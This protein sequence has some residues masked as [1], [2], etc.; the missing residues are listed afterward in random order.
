MPRA[1]G[2]D[3][4]VREPAQ[5]VVGAS[6]FSLSGASSLLVG[7]LHKPLFPPSAGGFLKLAG[8][9]K[10]LIVATN[11]NGTDDPTDTGILARLEFLRQTLMQPVEPFLGQPGDQAATVPAVT[12]PLANPSSIHMALPRTNY[13]FGVDLT[14]ADVRSSLRR[15][16]LM[17]DRYLVD[18]NL[19]DTATPAAIRFLG[20]ELGILSRGILGSLGDHP[21][22]RLRDFYKIICLILKGTFLDVSVPDPYL[23]LGGIIADQSPGTNQAMLLRITESLGW[24]LLF[25]AGRALFTTNAEAL[26][27]TSSKEP[28]DVKF[29]GLLSEAVVL[30]NPRGFNRDASARVATNSAGATVDHVI[31]TALAV[32]QPVDPGLPAAAVSLYAGLNGIARNN[33]ISEL[34]GQPLLQTIRDL[35]H[36]WRFATA[37]SLL[38]EDRSREEA[39]FVLA[40]LLNLY[41]SDPAVL[42]LLSYVDTSVATTAFVEAFGGIDGEDEMFNSA[43]AV[44]A[45]RMNRTKLMMKI[46]HNMGRARLHLYLA[47]AVQ[48]E[49]L[50]ASVYIL[51]NMVERDEYRPIID[52]MVRILGDPLERMTTVG[53]ET[54]DRLFRIIRDVGESGASL[55]GVSYDFA[56]S[57]GGMRAAQV[58]LDSY[59]MGDVTAESASNRLILGRS[60]TG[61]LHILMEYER[62]HPDR[63]ALATLSELLVHQSPDSIATFLTVLNDQQANAVS[64]PIRSGLSRFFGALSRSSE[65][66]IDAPEGILL[67]AGVDSFDLTNDGA[68][69]DLLSLLLRDVAVSDNARAVAAVDHM[70]RNNEL[71]HQGGRRL[72]EDLLEQPAI[73]AQSALTDLHLEL[74]N[75]PGYNSHMIFNTTGTLL[76][77]DL[78][79]SQRSAAID[80]CARIIRHRRG[81]VSTDRDL[82]FL[83]P[84]LVPAAQREAVTMLGRLGAHEKIDLLLS[85]V[86]GADRSLHGIEFRE[87][88]LTALEVIANKHPDKF[89]KAQAERLHRLYLSEQRLGTDIWREVR[90][91]IVTLGQKGNKNIVKMLG[92]GYEKIARG[93]LVARFEE[94]MVLVRNDLAWLSLIQDSFNPHAPAWVEFRRKR[95]AIL[96]PRAREHSYIQ[97]RIYR[98]LKPE[99]RIEILLLPY[100]GVDEAVSRNLFESQITSPLEYRIMAI[101]F[102]GR[103][104]SSYLIGR[105]GDY[106]YADSSKVGI[107][108]VKAIEMLGERSVLSGFIVDEMSRLGSSDPDWRFT[109]SSKDELAEAIRALGRL[110]V[111]ISAWLDNNDIYAT[112]LT[113]VVA[114]A[115]ALANARTSIPK[116]RQKLEELVNGKF[117]EEDLEAAIGISRALLQFGDDS[118]VGQVKEY[119]GDIVVPMS[120]HLM[121]G[122]QLLKSEK[123]VLPKVRRLAKLLAETNSDAS[124][125]GVA[126]ES[127]RL[128]VDDSR[129]GKMIDYDAEYRILV[130]SAL[131]RSRDPQYI[132][133]LKRVTDKRLEPS[134]IAAITA[135]ADM[136]LPEAN[137]VLLGLPTEQMTEKEMIAYATALG[138]IGSSAARQKLRD[139]QPLSKNVCIAVILACGNLGTLT[140]GEF[141]SLRAA[142]LD[143]DADIRKTALTSLGK[144]RNPE[145]EELLKGFLERAQGEENRRRPIIKPDEVKMAQEILAGINADRLRALADNPTEDSIDQLV[146]ALATSNISHQERSAVEEA[147]VRI[148]EPAKP[149]IIAVFQNPEFN[150]GNRVMASIHR[151]LWLIEYEAR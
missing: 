31:Q 98:G 62:N 148:G 80:K 36:G 127:G 11:S 69:L 108:A 115:L 84:Q 29:R 5:F 61:V 113:G 34:L 139:L 50:P 105:L 33:R 71:Y 118:F 32:F 106:L 87:E 88:A 45:Q 140:Q 28:D 126:G 120:T 90:G 128:N 49:T 68:R 14:S 19:R 122:V 16:L 147:L 39:V 94:G 141:A 37:A 13:D 55:D 116:L 67:T 135:L 100:L 101:D 46:L 27:F 89:T 111:D 3:A 26:N 60:P 58:R 131:G 99:E 8:A 138:K 70:V 74:S 124:I 1:G 104:G 142:L 42:D 109:L 91:I 9:S 35:S 103:A 65:T 24:S 79:G 86:E 77:D 125:F 112:G 95:L 96:A 2:L 15:S 17:F 119:L 63:P 6:A 129:I 82:A 53:A 12:Q 22:A 59:F 133:V 117:T 145:V 54:V 132:P 92:S 130:I 136:Q 41:P 81:T 93:L 18:A 76:V 75:L 121:V 151:V 150:Y 44:D 146:V 114:E 149:R 57:L 25:L 21:P 66:D 110:G 143:V 144:I 56:R 72:A 102:L 97:G 123:A 10:P 83:Q 43:E 107:A 134:R 40:Q 4:F 137:A 73:E 52:D 38:Q 23:H 48:H 78:S 64:S 20:E 30:S 7:D 85:L 47:G 51:A